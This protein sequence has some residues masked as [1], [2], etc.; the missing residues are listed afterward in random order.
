[1]YS[2]GS[3]LCSFLSRYTGA[4]G[5]PEGTDPNSTR[6]WRQYN[7]PDLITAE[8]LAQTF[9]EAAEA[10]AQRYENA[11]TIYE[12]RRSDT[13]KDPTKSTAQNWIYHSFTTAGKAPREW[14][15]HNI[16]DDGIND[17]IIFD[18]HPN[19]PKY[20]ELKAKYREMLEQ[21]SDQRQIKEGPGYKRLRYL[22]VDIHAHQTALR[23][24][25]RLTPNTQADND[26]I[27]TLREYQSPPIIS[28]DAGQKTV[29][30][31]SIVVATATLSAIDLRGKNI[32]EVASWEDNPVIPLRCLIQI[33][34]CQTGN[35]ESSNNTGELCAALLADSLIPTDMAALTFMDSQAV[36][37][38]LLRLRD[39]A[40]TISD[41]EKIRQIYPSLG[42]AHMSKAN[43]QMQRIHNTKFED[44]QLYAAEARRT[45]AMIEAVQQ[46]WLHRQKYNEDQ[47]DN[48]PYRPL[49]H[50]K[51]HQANANGNLKKANT[52]G[53]RAYPCFAA[54]SAN[55]YA[56]VPC[57][58]LLKQLS[59]ILDKPIDAIGPMPHWILI[60][61]YRDYSDNPNDKTYAQH[62]KE[63]E[64]QPYG[65]ANWP[66]DP[67]PHIIDS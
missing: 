6:Y 14:V 4:D 44:S 12:W 15:E 41:R 64:Q 54:V 57:G 20:K 30:G 28:T 67:N 61:S 40:D 43:T 33:V 35:I 59:R 63:T 23:T 17:E 42:K 5:P 36:R 60:T 7:L 18:L 13:D 39:H 1:M 3:P 29:N 56:D 34:P 25:L 48:H 16:Y 55:H 19:D 27:T 11:N 58:N 24:K 46:P 50:V 37:K 62:K 21:N 9:R 53:H 65:Y 22:P 52:P 32:Q 66:D 2:Y 31:A 51:S 8:R 26:L 47:F 10:Q 49:L 45:K 38:P